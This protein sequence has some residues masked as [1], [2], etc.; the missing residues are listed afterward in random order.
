MAA[1]RFGVSLEGLAVRLVAPIGR[2]AHAVNFSSRGAGM[3]A[4]TAAN[5]LL[6]DTV[7]YRGRAYTI[8]GF[9]AMSVVPAQIQLEPRRGGESFWVDRELVEARL[10]PEKAAFRR[11]PR[12]KDDK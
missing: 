4:A 12:R 5:M 9:T 8:V 10:V 2:V 3:Y 7:I 6:G 1:T 11:R